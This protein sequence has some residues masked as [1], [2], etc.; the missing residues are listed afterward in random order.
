MCIRDRDTVTGRPV[1]SVNPARLNAGL[2]YDT[3]GW[4]ARLDV[5]HRAAKKSGDIDNAS[6]V[7]PPA[8]Q[9]ATPAATTLD[10]S[11]Q[12]RIRKDLRLNAGI[13]NLTDRKYW[14]WSD[15]RGLAANTTVADAYTQPGR[16]LRV[17]LVADF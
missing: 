4:S 16:N 7:T 3:A 14:N 12:W 10:V 9:F 8:T 1:N 6:A 11:A 5:T 13:F 2:K 15:V 17:S